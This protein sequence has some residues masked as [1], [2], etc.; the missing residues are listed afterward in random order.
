MTKQ[1]GIVAK[2]PI[3]AGAIYRAMVRIFNDRGIG[4][5]DQPDVVVYSPKLSDNFTNRERVSEATEVMRCLNTKGG[6]IFPDMDPAEL[7]E[8]RAKILIPTIPTISDQDVEG[9]LDNID[10]MQPPEDPASDE[11]LRYAQVNN[12][13]SKW[14]D[15]LIKVAY[16]RDHG[17][18][19]LDGS[20]YNDVEMMEKCKDRGRHEFGSIACQGGMSP[21]SGVEFFLDTARKSESSILLMSVPTTPDFIPAIVEM[22]RNGLDHI[23]KS[24]NNPVPRL[25]E[26]MRKLSALDFDAM[27]SVCNT[28]HH[29]Y[30]AIRDWGHHAVH[31]PKMGVDSI[32]E[33]G[34]VHEKV[35]VLL[36]ATKASLDAKIF[37][38]AA[39]ALGR[40]DIEWLIP[41]AQ[42]DNVSSAIWENIIKGKYKEGGDILMNVVNAYQEIHGDDFFIMGGCTE[43]ALGIGDRIAEDRFIDNAAV[44]RD[45]CIKIA[46]EAADNRRER[47]GN[48]AQD[49]PE[50]TLIPYRGAAKG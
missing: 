33:P 24:L 4:Q 20:K 48:M 43:V 9:I 11:Y 46:M 47:P 39:A 10:N 37:E 15:F 7:T 21:Q 16:G 17:A 23:V 34:K 38:I 13:I 35:K 32:P 25:Q 40:T 19:V 14:A 3:I 42:Q 27:T 5:W 26:V 28:V 22:K 2:N 12:S 49:L 41:E 31:L 1:V 30:D 29:F 45:E 44:T 6:V 50:K 8:S 18:T 36:L